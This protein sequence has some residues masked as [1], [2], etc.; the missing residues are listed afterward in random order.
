[1][2]VKL[3]VFF[4]AMMVIAG[5][6]PYKMDIQQGNYVTPDARERL[7]L[8]M[9]QTQV[10]ALLGEPLIRDPFHPERWDYVYTFEHQKVLQDKQRLTLYFQGDRLARIDDAHMPPLP[11]SAPVPASA[12]IGGTPP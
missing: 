6:G 2:R 12:P 9:S 8:G 7:K 4:L 11:A 3:S 10:R 5:C 1:M